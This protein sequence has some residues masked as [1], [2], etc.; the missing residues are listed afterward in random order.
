[1]AEV[2]ATATTKDALEMEMPTAD[3]LTS[4]PVLLPVPERKLRIWNTAMCLFHTT[5]AV[6]TLAVG[7]LDLRVPVYG[8]ELELITAAN[9]SD[10]WQYVPASPARRVS[11]LYLTW[12]TACFFLLSALAHLGNAL[13][14]RRHYV[15]ALKHGCA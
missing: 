6:V 15:A 1:M 14:W 3:K 10:A 9:N 2:P 13:L 5:L 12:L 11:W 7:D 4:S 8:S